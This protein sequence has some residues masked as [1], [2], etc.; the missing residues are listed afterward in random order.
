MH[1][2]NVGSQQVFPIAYCVLYANE[3][4]EYMFCDL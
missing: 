4:G 1:Y 3:K 2:K